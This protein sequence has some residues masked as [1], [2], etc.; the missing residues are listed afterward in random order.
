MKGF[1]LNKIGPMFLHFIFY[2]IFFFYCSIELVS[3]PVSEFP[4][5]D[6]RI[7]TEELALEFISNE[8]YDE[9]SDNLLSSGE[10]YELELMIGRRGSNDGELLLPISMDIFNNELYVVDYGNSRIQ[11]FTLEGKFKRL[12]SLA[13]VT[14]PVHLKITK[15]NILVV[16]EGE[17]KLFIF[18]HQG[19]IIKTMG[20]AGVGQGKLNSPNSV[21]IDSQGLYWISDDKNNRITIFSSNILFGKK[22]H[23]FMNID[24][25]L[26]NRYLKAPKGLFAVT[27]KDRIYVIESGRARIISFDLNG[28]YKGPVLDYQ[29]QEGKVF[30]PQSIFVD[31]KQNIYVSDHV[32]HKILKYSVDG[33]SLGEIGFLDQFDLDRSFVKKDKIDEGSLVPMIKTSDFLSE[34]SLLSFPQEVKTDFYGD[35]FVCD[36]GSNHIKKFSLS[37]FRKALKSYKLRKFEKA[38]KYFEK[39]KQR[40]PKRHLVEFYVAMC[41]YYLGMKESDFEEKRSR[42]DMA[43]KFLNSLK[44][45]NEIGKFRNK[46]IRDK[47]YYYLSRVNSYHLE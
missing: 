17:A 15:E 45:K 44:L 5:L 30:I 18:N 35:L 42:F 25:Y 6:S 10:Q 34:D 1:L 2:I 33:D 40:N 24:E 12:L 26:P 11:I 47:T 20:G 21:A 46:W 37:F 16:D 7:K 39:C 28:N 14:K 4:L 36:W 19:Q 41:H 8:S 32:S 31:S 23:Y 22:D 13:G 29:K 27:E 43:R 3:A 38:I 9:L